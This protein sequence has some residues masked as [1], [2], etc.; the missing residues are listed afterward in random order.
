M[1][2]YNLE[3]IIDIE[4]LQG[5]QDSFSQFSGI[6]AVITNSEGS[7]ITRTS[8]FTTN[9]NDVSRTSSHS[10]SKCMNFFIQGAKKSISDNKPFINK[11]HE[12]LY[13]II[14]PIMLKE[15]FIGALVCGQ[16]LC[17]DEECSPEFKNNSS[18]YHKSAEEI[19]NIAKYAFNIAKLISAALDKTYILIKSNQLRYPSFYSAAKEVPK[20]FGID[21]IYNIHELTSSINAGIEVICKKF[22]ITLNI[23]ILSQIPGELL[24][25]PAAIQYIIEGLVSFIV[26]YITDNTLNIDFSCTEKYYSRN[27]CMKISVFSD[28]NASEKLNELKNKFKI[29]QAEKPEGASLITYITNKILSG[30]IDF[31]LSDENTITATLS[32]PQLDLKVD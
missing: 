28:N 3:E 19:Q 2:E 31:G 5:F 6:A 9:C 32:I 15:Q 18:V 14:A 24:G 12:G 11:C 21:R 26:P 8:G 20:D 1:Q 4:L 29:V 10:I 22:N 13:S 30:S 7:C 25:N 17:T 16:I 27:L 23:S